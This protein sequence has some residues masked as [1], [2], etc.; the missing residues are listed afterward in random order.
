MTTGRS[1]RRGFTLVEL[2]ISMVVGLVV[3]G[4]SLSFA[5]T[6]FRTIQGNQVRGGVQKAARFIGMSLERDLQS[7]GVGLASTPSFGSLAVWGDTIVILG[8]AYAPTESPPYDLNPPPGASNPLAPGGTCGA[9][10][11]DLVYPGMTFD[12]AAGDVA[13]LQ[14]NDERR[15][16]QVQ[17]VASGSGNAI[18]E[19]TGAASV[20]NY[21]AGFSGGLLLDRFST[22]VQKLS[23]VVYWVEDGK[24][25]RAQSL[26]SDGS[27]DG[28]VMAYGVQ[29][30]TVTVT[31]RDGDQANR[32]DPADTDVTNDFDDVVGLRVHA[33]LAA[34]RPV[35]HV[36]GGSLFTRTYDWRFGPR[37]LM[38]ERNRL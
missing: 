16:I 26:R 37:N 33:V 17:G 38:Y 34:D 36:A 5:T 4:A 6:T 10:C 24:L 1:D 14:V 25:M 23:T 12:L 35:Q 2:L 20:L 8:V 13:R 21:G 30:W 32:I 19:F 7:T 15:L 31:F 18:L 29:E 11:L 3:L 9:S 27:L 28:A 22:F